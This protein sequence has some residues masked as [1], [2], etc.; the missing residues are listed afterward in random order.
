MRII[1]GVRGVKIKISPQKLGFGDYKMRFSKSDNG[2]ATGSTRDGTSA[3]VDP[4]DV[5]VGVTAM[6]DNPP[7]IR[8]RENTA[9]N[10]QKHI[11]PIAARIKQQLDGLHNLRSQAIEAALTIEGGFMRYFQGVMKSKPDLALNFIGK[12][13]PH[14][15]ESERIG[16]E[17]APIL[18]I[19]ATNA[20]VNAA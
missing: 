4:I 15:L 13:M 19:N 7:P 18:I 8:I 1:R 20:Q 9:A 2:W 14:D 12:M 16:P 3:V 11:S 6:A 17:R 5:G 10:M